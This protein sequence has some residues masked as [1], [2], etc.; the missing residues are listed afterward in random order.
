MHRARPSWIIR[1]QLKADDEPSFFISY[2]SIY[3]GF[4]CLVKHTLFTPS[5]SKREKSE[6]MKVVFAAHWVSSS[7]DWWLGQNPGR[8]LLQE[9]KKSGTHNRHSGPACYLKMITN[10]TT[11]YNRRSL[12]HKSPTKDK[13]F[14]SSTIGATTKHKVETK[15][16]RIRKKPAAQAAG[17][18]PFDATPSTDKI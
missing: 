17:A 8:L 12:F 7:V 18:D 14:T 1:N 10:L 3:D 15:T 2:T 13:F 9:D 5:L 4:I 11:I 6:V 16:K